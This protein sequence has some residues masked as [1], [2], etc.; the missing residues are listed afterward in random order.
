MSRG[1]MLLFYQKLKKMIFMFPQWRFWNQIFQYM[2]AKHIAIGNEKIVTTDAP[3]FGI[4]DEPTEKFKIIRTW[5]YF[6]YINF[7]LNKI[8]FILAKCRIIT[9]VRQKYIYHGWFSI[10]TTWYVISK[11]LFWKIKFIDWF[12]VN[13]DK[14]I[15]WKSLSIHKKY[16]HTA[17]N[18][19]SQIPKDYHKVF[20][21][22]RRWDYL[23]WSV[24]WQKDVSIPPSYY[25]DQIDFFQK[26]YKNVFFVFLSDDIDYVK[27]EFGYL[28][29]ALFSKNDFWTDFA[30]M[31]LCD[32]AIL[33]VSTLSYLWA[34]F[35]KNRIE[36][37]APKYRLWFKKKIWYPEWIVTEKFDFVDTD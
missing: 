1:M 35:M 33:S 3:Y 36:I 16:I 9:Y 30:I 2:F 17:N 6:R 20:V 10:Q 21:H 26:K 13:E 5:K 27:N 4:I 19:L 18:F 31:T 14:H 22:I 11:G 29:N 12:F 15:I 24:L 32:G 25:K 7:W 34:Y 23:E 28:K 8:F 37:F